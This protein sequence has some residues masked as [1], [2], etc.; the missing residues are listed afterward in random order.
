MTKKKT[1]VRFGRLLAIVLFLLVA[2]RGFIFVLD[3]ADIN[4]EEVYLGS[5]EP[6]LVVYL[7]EEKTE[8]FEVVRGMKVLAFDRY[9]A[10][11]TLRQ[12]QIDD[13]TYYADVNNIVYTYQGVIFETE[14][15][16]RTTTNIYSDMNGVDIVKHINKSERIEL[17][18]GNLLPDGTVD[19][20]QTVDGYIRSKYLVDTQ[21]EADAIY[22]P[23]G[24]FKAQSELVN[25]SY[26]QFY[27][28][29]LDMDF[30]PREKVAYENNPMPEELYTIYLHNVD[31]RYI[32]YYIDLANRTNIN[33]F[34]MDLK[35]SSYINYESAVAAKYS[36]SMAAT[37]D[38]TVEEYQEIIQ[39]VHDAGIYTIG[40]MTVFKDKRLVQDHPEVAIQD[41]RTNEPLLHND[42]YWPSAYSRFVWQYNVEFALEAIE[43]FGFNE[44]Q[45][46]YIRFP[47]QT[48]K[49][50]E[51]NVIDFKNE[52]DE[53]KGTVIQQ[54]L[55]Y[56][57]DAL[58][59]EEVY[60]AG[61]VFGEAAKGF[62]TLYGQYWPGI[63]N[64][65]DVI[66]P[67]AYPDHFAMWEYNLD[68]PWL[69]PYEISFAVG[70][71]MYEMQQ[72][73]PNPAVVRPWIQGYNTWKRN[74]FRYYGEAYIDQIQG[75]Y[76]A[77][78]KNG[79]MIWHAGQ[80]VR[81]RY[82]YEDRGDAL[83]I[84]YN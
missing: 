51:E 53:S 13:Q 3:N 68:Y 40:R 42:T 1:R 45:F 78:L 81:E 33:A 76:D 26:P 67:M 29:I 55:M 18:G 50:E 43:L 34:V 52:F 15:F 46:D 6:T 84:D 10:E 72:V 54:F 14:K 74:G 77:G 11:E 38:F 83:I 66:A 59:E 30:Y 56:A 17:F 63:S 22:D 8:T 7:D 4:S 24:Y 41:L 58:S 48:Q 2:V 32:D 37:A 62:E 36:P 16:V 73:T 82:E 75:Y 5:D 61:D 60:V 79:F 31:L 39:K 65:V 23:T 49:L 69:Y 35:E 57:Y 71:D 80:S 47:D 21:E 70:E 20:Y 12:I 25:A 64:V 44:I 27:E 9:K 19:W 28:N